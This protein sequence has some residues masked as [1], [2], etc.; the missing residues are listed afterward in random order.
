LNIFELS[1]EVFLGSVVL[2]RS[3]PLIT[4]I[5]SLLDL[6][7]VVALEL[8]SELVAVVDGSTHGIQVLFEALLGFELLLK[9][10][11][12]FGVLLGIVNHTLNVFFG[13]AALIV[14]DSDGLGL[15]SATLFGSD[16][17]D[18]ILI[19]LEG[20]FN[21]GGTTRSGRDTSQIKFTE[22]MVVL[23]Q[24]TF[25][26]VN[27]NFDSGLHILSGCEWLGFL[28]WDNGTTWDNLGHHTTLNLDS[29]SK[30]SNI[31]KKYIFS[32]VTSFTA[33]NTSLDGST[34]SNSLIRIDTTIRFFS[35]KEVTNE[36]LNLRNTG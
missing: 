19:N 32:L 36:L 20:D 15:A 23:N 8:I 14:G 13:E 5:E 10:S 33:K 12:S 1:L 25:S 21:L 26:F 35:I 29:K 18:G 27:C 24:S 22:E 9:D 11:V 2:V 6:R 34:I 17:K 28:S 30:R 4:F 31:D 16:R 7:F 3:E